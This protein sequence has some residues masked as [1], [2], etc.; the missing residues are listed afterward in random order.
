MS[1]AYNPQQL[2]TVLGVP[3]NVANATQEVDRT[4][5]A[6]VGTCLRSNG[7]MGSAVYDPKLGGSVPLPEVKNRIRRRYQL[8]H[9]LNFYLSM[10][11]K[12]R[13]RYLNALIDTTDMSYIEF[14]KIANESDSYNKL[15]ADAKLN[16]AKLSEVGLKKIVTF[17]DMLSAV[18]WASQLESDE[19]TLS[20]ILKNKG[21]FNEFFGRLTH[22]NQLN[23]R[24]A[25][26]LRSYESAQKFEEFL[27][28]F[29][30]CIN[31]GLVLN[32]DKYMTAI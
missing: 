26:L 29:N 10:K 8:N 11:F 18:Q 17:G 28:L 25:L 2:A 6:K 32:H 5:F 24:S 3:T 19:Y 4:E 16:L 9:W 31:R 14:F 1:N 13:S 30:D 21:E 12:D 15:T 23:L 7:D 22:E 20:S 27:F